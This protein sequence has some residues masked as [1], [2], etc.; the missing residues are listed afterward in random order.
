MHLALAAYGPG[1]PSTP[2]QNSFRVKFG[3]RY[4]VDG[5]IITFLNQQQ[6][7]IDLLKKRLK[8]KAV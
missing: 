7:L 3:D 1:M 4:L 8:E 5:E 6:Q 2:P